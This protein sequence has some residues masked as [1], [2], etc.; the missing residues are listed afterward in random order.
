MPAAFVVSIRSAAEISIAPARAVI[1]IMIDETAIAGGRMRFL[2]ADNQTLI[3]ELFA[4]LLTQWSPILE[5]IHA[6]SFAQVLTRAPKGTLLDL[7][8]LDL[9]LPGMNRL[10][11]LQRL[12]A[13]HPKV[14]VL[15]LSDMAT[16]DLVHSAMNAGA[17][18]VIPK[19]MSSKGAI[20][21]IQLVLSGERFMPDLRS[22]D[23]APDIVSRRIGLRRSSKADAPL[24]TLSNRERNVLSLLITGI[25]NKEIAKTLTVEAV[26]IGV[27]L[28]SIYR[29]LGVVNRTQAVRKALELGW[30]SSEGQKDP[31]VRE[32]SFS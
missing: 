27:H 1:R 10:A 3:R 22:H 17:A 29:K 20:G 6:S 26:T 14:P 18:G 19:T 15:L 32:G 13:L 30:V 11:G 9:Q 21:A 16:P 2:L 31:W 7:I 5:L 28:S 4:L 25:S 23:L 24:A 8:L 12:H